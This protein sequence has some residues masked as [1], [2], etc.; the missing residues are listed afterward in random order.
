MAARQIIVLD[1]QKIGG[2]TQVSG[3][4][5][6]IAP[7]NRVRP[8]PGAVSALPPVASVPTWGITAGE[9]A[10]LQAGATIEQP[11]TS[12]LFSAG[13]SI[14]NIESGLQALY[15]AAQAALNNAGPG[16]KFVGSSWDGTTWTVA[17]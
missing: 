6:L 3:V 17:P 12:G 16:A 15:T 2:D 5:W 9:L 13:T 10:S 8:S 11:F 14:P 4:F 7:A 1:I